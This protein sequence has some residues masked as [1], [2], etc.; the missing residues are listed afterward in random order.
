[1]K[2]NK[3]TGFQALKNYFSSPVIQSQTAG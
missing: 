3:K 1:M 2:D